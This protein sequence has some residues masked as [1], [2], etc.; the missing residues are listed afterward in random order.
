MRLQ[1][2]LDVVGLGV[3][4]AHQLGDV[5][6]ADVA[7]QQLGVAQRAHAALALDLV[8]LEGEVHLLDAV[9]LGAGAERR[10]GAAQAAAVEHA[11]ARVQHG[12]LGRAPQLMACG[13]P[14]ENGA[15]SASKRSPLV[16]TI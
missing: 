16:V 4:A 6:E 10:L 9:A 11:I 13:S 15:I 12:S 2:L 8:A 14:S 3:V 1:D 5:G 7:V